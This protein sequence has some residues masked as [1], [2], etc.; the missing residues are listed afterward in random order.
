MAAGRLRCAGSLAIMADT[1]S[2]SKRSGKLRR[3]I[4][5]RRR[6]PV[7]GWVRIWLGPALGVALWLHS[8][9]LIGLVLLAMASN[10]VWLPPPP[11]TRSWFTRVSEGERLWLERSDWLEKALV[12]G[13]PGLMLLP[14][15][16]ALWHR[17]AAWTAFFGVAL[18]GHRWLLRF[19][20]AQITDAVPR[21]DRRLSGPH[22]SAR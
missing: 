22:G 19:W 14:L 18:L 21:E 5:R 13:V 7:S 11:H 3:L 20:A 17:H 15:A 2:S 12:L 8:W 6:N 4:W 10:P 9:P 16:L 1:R